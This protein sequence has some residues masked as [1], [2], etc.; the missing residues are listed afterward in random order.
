MS[1]QHWGER[2]DIAE[3]GDGGHV[4]YISELTILDFS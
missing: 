2:G 1:T 3:R 4:L